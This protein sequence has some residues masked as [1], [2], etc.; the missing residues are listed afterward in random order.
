L[1]ALP[2][3]YKYSAF[4]LASFLSLRARRRL[5]SL[6]LAECDVEPQ[7]L[8]LDVGVTADTSR[9]E[10]NFFEQWFPYPRRIVAAGIED[11]SPLRRRFAGLCLVQ[12]RGDQLPFRDDSFDV[13]FSNAVLEHVGPWRAQRRFVGELSRVCTPPC[14]WCTIFRTASFGGRCACWDD[15]RLRT[16]TN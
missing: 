7:S 15:Q 5:L 6:F 14:H 9:P 3:Y 13:V 12:A 1:T 2:T 10:S 16:Q 11:V 8:V 4:G